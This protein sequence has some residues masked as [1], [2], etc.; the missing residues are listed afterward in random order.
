M[1]GQRNR[2]AA[3]TMKYRSRLPA[4]IVTTLSCSPGGR[5]T[6]QPTVSERSFRSE[7]RERSASDPRSARQVS[8]R[9]TA[10]GRS[11]S[12]NPSVPGLGCWG[13]VAMQSRFSK[14]ADREI[15]SL[16]ARPSTVGRDILLHNVDQPRKRRIPR[17]QARSSIRQ[18]IVPLPKASATR[19]QSFGIVLAVG[20]PNSR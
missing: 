4:K 1:T 18:R 8:N 11:N 5:K 15:H 12:C 17:L 9:A 16:I 7:M 19:A 3:A 10:K 14:P 6:T 20:T 2:L 13:R